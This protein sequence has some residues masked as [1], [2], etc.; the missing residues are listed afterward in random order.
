MARYQHSTAAQTFINHIASLPGTSKVTIASRN[1]T[2][3]A[4][5][6]AAQDEETNL[7]RLFAT[8][9]NDP[10]LQ[11]LT[12]GLVSVF[13]ASTPLAVR[14]TRMRD[15]AKLSDDERRESY[16]FPLSD[17]A[18]RADGQH[19]MAYNLFEFERRWNVFTEGAL[20]RLQNWN[21]VIAAG[22]AVLACLLPMDDG[23][24]ENRRS[25]RKYFHT[26]AYPSSDIDLFL[27]GLDSEEVSKAG[28][29][30]QCMR[31]MLAYI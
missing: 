5:L 1:T 28:S 23:D 6:A 14:L 11:D 12:V 9:P 16:V 13:D 15:V 22:G 21:N 19:A 29:D 7:R 17:E 31:L 4:I 3:D 18:R 24:G 27:Y 8:K 20:S 2:L 25:M 10:S 30:L 26:K